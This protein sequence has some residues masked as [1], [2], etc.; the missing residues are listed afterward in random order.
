MKRKLYILACAMFALTFNACI[1]DDSGMGGNV[2]PELTIAGDKENMSVYNF[3]L[4]TNC[5]ISPEITYKGGTESELTYTWSI[6][7]YN[8]S[9]KGEA[10]EV[11]TER[12]LNYFFTKGGS[13]YAHLVVTDGKVGQAMDYRININRTFEE[14]YVLVSANESG[15]GNLT[16]VKIMTPEE[17]AAGASQVYMEHCLK[18]MNNDLSESTLRNAVLGTA[19]TSTGGSVDRLLVST[20][21][22]CYFL[23]PNTFT[24]I[25]EIDYASTYPGFKATHFIPDDYSPYAY[26]SSMKKFV[27]LDM[28]FMFSYEYNYYL[29][30]S[31]DD[32]YL[33]QY[34]QWGSSVTKT[35]F[36][37]Y[38]PSVVAEFNAYAPWYGLDTYFPSTENLLAKDEILSTFVSEEYDEVNY[39]LPTHILTRSTE[40][41]NIIR[42]Y[43]QDTYSY[44]FAETDF[45]AVECTLT[46]DMALPKQGTRFVS[47]ATYHRYFYAVDNSIY[48]FLRNNAFTL[49][50]KN[51]AAITFADDKEVTYLSVNAETEELYVAVYNKTSKRGSF[52][53]F[54]TA[55]VRADNQS[56]ATPKKSFK[57]CADK[58]SSV[59]YKP[60]IAN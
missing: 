52:Y 38:N 49:P 27:H 33:S 36:V 42:L 19:T 12:N 18:S 44:T 40:D 32:F 14:G 7:T 1:D 20:A 22:K 8:N 10:E 37:N 5:V 51:E 54:N 26:D 34:T 21:D 9:I 29:G 35:L 11:S 58:I 43:S 23:D 59:L 6:G 45:A 24:A 17:E 4:G 31:F 28:A 25:S 41:P 47:S 55:D 39:S 13:Y 3:D 57:N 46:A 48:V 56:S 16:F 2:L 60:S 15:E 30:N 53:I 50:K